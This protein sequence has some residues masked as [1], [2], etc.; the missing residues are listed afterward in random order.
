MIQKT[1]RKSRVFINRTQINRIQLSR[2]LF[3]GKIN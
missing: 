1:Q 2:E 3:S